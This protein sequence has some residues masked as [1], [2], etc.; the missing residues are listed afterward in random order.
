MNNLF[1]ADYFHSSNQTIFNNACTFTN[2]MKKKEQPEQNHK[3]NFILQYFNWIVL[4]K[5]V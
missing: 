3:N 2:D 4:R 1:I 5:F